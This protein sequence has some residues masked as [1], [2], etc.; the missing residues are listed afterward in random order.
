MG[1]LLILVISGV[2]FLKMY[3]STI[4]Y[5]LEKIIRPA[6]AYFAKTKEYYDVYP[7]FQRC[8]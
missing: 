1:I 7:V 8:S 3:S 4:S 5:L 2:D 6:I